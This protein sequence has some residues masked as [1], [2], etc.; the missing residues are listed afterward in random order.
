MQAA[1][2]DVQRTAWGERVYADSAVWQGMN[3]KL[4]VGNTAFTLIQSKA[5][6]QQYEVAV[7]ANLLNHFYPTLEL[8]YGLCQDE[9]E[10]GRYE[11]QGAFMRVGIDLNPLRKGRNRYYALLAGVRLGVDLQQ[12]SLS[13]VT[14]NDDYWADGGL[15]R[16]YPATFRADCWGEV[17][18]GM[19]IKVAGP[20]TMGWYAR[21]RFL[22]TGSVGNHQPY[23]IP[24]YGCV[25]GSSFGFNYYIG[26]RI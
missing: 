2:Q 4:D 18:A 16:Q 26:W 19:Q 22:F 3:V 25:D 1:K 14:L 11:G 21:I 8:G 9:A 13:D 6:T 24:G 17:V 15:L 7:N 12:Y 5:R 20:L 10:G 23:Y